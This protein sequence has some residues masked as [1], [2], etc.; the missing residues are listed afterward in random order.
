MS[1]LTPLQK[2]KRTQKLLIALTII[3]IVTVLVLLRGLGGKP[4]PKAGG[5]ILTQEATEEAV[6]NLQKDINIPKPFFEGKLLQQFNT[7]DLLEAP[8]VFGRENPFI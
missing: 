6:R 5:P 8:E 2:R 1:K 3:V 4:A 7:Y